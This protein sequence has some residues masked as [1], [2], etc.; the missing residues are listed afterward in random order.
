MG[1]EQVPSPRSPAAQQASRR[2]GAKGRGPRTPHGK[3][4][5]ARNAIKHGF[6][7]RRSLPERLPDWLQDLEG[8]LMVC[9]GQ[10]GPGR[11]EYLDQVLRA[12][13]LLREIDQLIDTTLRRAIAALDPG[14]DQAVLLEADDGGGA[15][16]AGFGMGGDPGES[17]QLRQLK[18]LLGYRRRFRSSRDRGL[19]KLIKTGDWYARQAERERH[20]Q[21]KSRRKD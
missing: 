13:F 1:N 21:L 3:A 4:R 20:R 17:G 6:R 11:H 12:E 14:A 15:Q 7:S 18:V 19:R 9:C 10:T 5:A 16:E 2:N 8:E